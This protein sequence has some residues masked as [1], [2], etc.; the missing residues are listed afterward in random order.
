[1][2]NF[3][4][5]FKN[6]S[7]TISATGAI[8]IDP[9]RSVMK[10]TDSQL[11]KVI[12]SSG[13]S[14]V[15]PSSPVPVSHYSSHKPKLSLNAAQSEYEMPYTHS[16]VIPPSSNSPKFVKRSQN[17]SAT[18]IVSKPIINSSDSQDMNKSYEK[19]SREFVPYT[20]KDYYIIK[21]KT[22]YQLGG[23]GPA[24]IGTND[25]L[26]KKELNDKKMRYGKNIYY[27]NA[28]KL[29]L[30]PMST[31]QKNNKDVLNSRSRALN[32]AKTI[33]KPPLRIS[34]SPS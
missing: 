20:I 22:Y 21:P 8:F 28:A 33:I 12:Q 34:L 3:Q 31:H 10:A 15:N 7:S 5:R 6:K 17:Q 24:N 2:S 14:I 18:P 27:L 19:K 13:S 26:H 23:L 9:H 1:M 25:W 29:P 30:L 16:S 4:D 11:H 32:F